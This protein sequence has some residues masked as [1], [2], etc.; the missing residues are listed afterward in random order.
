MLVFA[1]EAVQ[2]HQAELTVE[3]GRFFQVAS[4]LADQGKAITEMVMP[5]GLVDEFWHEREL[6]SDF[7]IFVSDWTQDEFTHINDYDQ[8]P[9]LKGFGPIPWI[10]LYEEMFGTMS[11]V[12]FMDEQGIL[13]TEAYDRYLASKNDHQKSDFQAAWNCG[14]ARK[15]KPVTNELVAALQP[16]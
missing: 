1:N 15:N 4:I 8:Y 10:P 2:Q 11:S 12:W 7:S 13:D 9:A 5:K 6:M 3:L 14:P 16:R